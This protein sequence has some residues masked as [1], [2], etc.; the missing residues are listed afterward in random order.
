MSRASIQDKFSG[1]STLK[2]VQVL[3]LVRAC[4]EHAASIGAPLPT[5]EVDERVWQQKVA[6]LEAFAPPSAPK[7][8]EVSSAAP[9]THEAN[10]K[11][12]LPDLE[13]MAIPIINAG[14]TDIAT[15]VREGMSQPIELWLPA[16]LKA[17]DRAGMEDL[18]FL[19]LGALASPE[20]I[21]NILITM[22]SEGADK[23]ANR[24]FQV[25][26]L[27]QPPH[28]IPKILVALRRDD[29]EAS[30]FYAQEFMDALLGKGS[31]IGTSRPDLAE[32]LRALRAV[33]LDKD[34][35]NLAEG[36]GMLVWPR[37]ALSIAGAFGQNF[38]DDRE[39]ILAAVTR[40]GPNRLLEVLD[41]LDGEP[42]DGVDPQE[43][44]ESLLTFI[45]R[46][47]RE[48]FSRVL[49]GAGRDREAR[50][51]TELGDE[52]PF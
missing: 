44:V 38:Y 39:K 30:Y 9:P 26:L 51:V 13:R 18:E 16:V 25:C 33:T 20:Q 27:S 46:A 48:Q 29:A 49:T 50:R 10:T 1:S 43:T 23:A 36:I 8:S 11:R 14:M 6:S 12:G 28:Q 40:Q 3:A 34:A 32:V 37:T 17:L 15:L 31:W 45:Q 7:P 4:A 19:K 2:M 22:D 35:D 21:V 41:A 42:I 52:L 47:K 24:Y 5:E